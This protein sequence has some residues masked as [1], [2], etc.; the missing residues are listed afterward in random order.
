MKIKTAL[1][2]VTSEPHRLFFA[3]GTLYMIS[4]IFWWITYL[5]HKYFHYLPKYLFDVKELHTF[6]MLYVVLTCY[7]LGFLLTTYPRWLQQ[8]ALS[9]AKGLLF[10]ILIPL[11]GVVTWSGTKLYLSSMIPGSIMVTLGFALWVAHLAG[12]LLKTQV[13]E[14][15]QPLFALLAVTGGLIGSVS[16]TLYLLNR[17]EYLYYQITYGLGMYFY[18]PLLILTLLW[19]LLPFFTS[20][21]MGATGMNTK[22]WVLSSWA[23]LLAAKTLVFISG[24]KEWFLLTDSLLLLVTLH[25]FKHWKFWRKKPTMLLSYLYISFLW[26]PIGLVLYIFGAA[27]AIYTGSFYSPHF[28]LAGL[29]AWSMGFIASLIF[30]MSTRVTRGHSGRTLEV[31]KFEDRLFWLIQ[32]SA[33]FRVITE[34]GGL[35]DI[36]ISFWAF[37]AGVFWLIGFTLWAWRYLPIYFAPRQDQADTHPR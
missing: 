17:G 19:R 30:G 23:I 9:R 25:Q 4:A 18:I 26:F 15:F 14:R 32:F 11:G 36:R 2:W 37:V 24:H 7:A 5:G 12:I 22:P 1:G 33:I 20:V 28:E 16:F 10:F 34:L 27:W 29:H 31:G 8:P 3:S 35:I 6:L 21:I 13:K